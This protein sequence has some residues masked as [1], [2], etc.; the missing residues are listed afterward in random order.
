MNYTWI[1]F[2]FF[3]ALSSCRNSNPTLD[4]AE[5]L[6]ASNPQGA[7]E[8]LE[9]INPDKLSDD[10]RFSYGISLSEVRSA[11]KIPLGDSSLVQ[12]CYDYPNSHLFKCPKD[13]VRGAF[14]RAYYAFQN[15]D[16]ED[17]VNYALI[18]KEIA[19][20]N[21]LY[22]WCGRIAS[23][24]VDI[25]EYTYNYQEYILNAKEAANYFLK[26]DSIHHYQFAILEIAHIYSNLGKTKEGLKL[27]DSVFKDNNYYAPSVEYYS[28][29]IRASLYLRDHNAEKALK[30]LKEIPESYFIGSFEE[31]V[32]EGLIYVELGKLEKA[33]SVVSL[34]MKEGN[35]DEFSH[36][37]FLRVRA[38]LAFARGDYKN[39]YLLEEQMADNLY[40][41]I[42]GMMANSSVK[43]QSK[44]Y[45]ELSSHRKRDYIFR[46]NIF[47]A[48][49]VLLLAVI[50]VGGLSWRRA[51]VRR[52]RELTAKEEQLADLR[53]DADRLVADMR[54]SRREA[55]TASREAQSYRQTYAAMTDTLNF[56]LSQTGGIADTSSQSMRQKRIDD[57]VVRIESPEFMKPVEDYIDSRT[58]GLIA[59]TRTAFAD[60]EIKDRDYH[61]LM[62]LALG[63]S[64][65]G[66]MAA[67]GL[68]QSTF[69]TR[70]KRLRERIASSSFPRRDELL[71]YL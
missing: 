54:A 69:Y 60:G 14:Y 27:L 68:N 46:R 66:V 34:V 4:E 62:L 65:Q 5:G 13:I 50:V 56:I 16:I 21:K 10:D 59:D 19:E 37:D 43:L 48:A 52:R 25:S 35:E 6:V 53:H 20:E 29:E 15:G 61:L 22:L 63:M 23:L 33:D 64:T 57:I 41:T 67:L 18:A 11:L 45:D 12:F 40:E 39:A 42:E 58:G 26:I 70:R 28:K 31:R 2:I 47:A 51:Y 24:M 9:N 55:E 38:A 44:F 1:I 7:L 71:A 49:L 8:I 30:T 3:F 17:A 36:P 32:F